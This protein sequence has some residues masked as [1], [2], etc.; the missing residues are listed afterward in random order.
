MLLKTVCK[1]SELQ[2]NIVAEQSL[3]TRKSVLRTFHAQLILVQAYAAIAYRRHIVQ[4]DSQLVSVSGHQRLSKLCCALRDSSCNSAS[5]ASGSATC[6]D[7]ERDN[8]DFNSEP[9]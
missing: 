2:P 8:I 4:F 6:G 9:Q 1:Q 3:N 5:S 7:V